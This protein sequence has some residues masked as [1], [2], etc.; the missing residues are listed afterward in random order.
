MN[1]GD[2]GPD[3]ELQELFRG[4]R[5]QEGE[6][7]PSFASMVARAREAAAEEPADP[8][9]GGEELRGGSPLPGAPP[10]REWAPAGGTTPRPP[11]GGGRMRWI[12]PLVAAAVVAT[13]LISQRG[14]DDREFDRLVNDWSRTAQVALQSP[15][16]RLL[17]VPGSQYLRSVPQLGSG[18]PTST[19]SPGRRP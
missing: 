1:G 15:T 13:L 14:R 8:Q 5:A 9:E 12:P 7:V 18:L 2:R 11:R 3:G 16:D 4:L 10:V 6:T 17:A 19:P